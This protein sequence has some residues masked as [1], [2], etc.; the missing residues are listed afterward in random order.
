VNPKRN[1]SR[2]GE[3]R[4]VMAYGGNHGVTGGGYRLAELLP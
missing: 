3:F 4:T 1:N 2:V